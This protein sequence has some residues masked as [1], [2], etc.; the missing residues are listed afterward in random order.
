MVINWVVRGDLHANK[1]EDTSPVSGRKGQKY[2]FES[3]ITKD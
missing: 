2:Q 3:N 1:A